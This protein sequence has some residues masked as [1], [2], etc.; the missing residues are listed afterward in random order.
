[1]FNLIYQGETTNTIINHHLISVSTCV[2]PEHPKTCVDQNVK[3]LKII[4][5]ER[6]QTSLKVFTT[7]ISNFNVSLVCLTWKTK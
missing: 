7:L 4:F 6:K 1:M 3:I 2:Y 5:L